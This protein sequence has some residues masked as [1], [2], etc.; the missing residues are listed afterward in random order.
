MAIRIEDRCRQIVQGAEP[1]GIIVSLAW[2]PAS[3]PRNARASPPSAFIPEFCG[4]RS[5]SFRDGQSA[6]AADQALA[7]A[8]R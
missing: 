5:C 3:C 1:S 7:G 2:S 4:R 8:V 6:R